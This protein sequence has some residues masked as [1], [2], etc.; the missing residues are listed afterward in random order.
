MDN[1]KKVQEVAS[2]TPAPA[3]QPQIPVQRPAL[4]HATHRGLAKMIF[5]GMVTFGI[6][7]LVIYCRLADEINIVACRHDGRKTMPFLAMCLSC[8]YTLGIVYLVWITRFCSRI[9]NE[10]KRRNISYRFGAGTFW[11]WNVL[12]SMIIVGPFIYTH[13]LMKAM[14][15][16]NKDYNERG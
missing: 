4:Q 1:E 13:K 6:Y 12:G 7:P 8:C 3:P 10:L 2:E 16:I 5:L 9:G 11:L 14:N 15:L